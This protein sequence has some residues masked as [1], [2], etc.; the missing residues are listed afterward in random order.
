MILE[1]MSRL[2]TCLCKTLEDEGRPTNFCGVIPGDSPVAS[3]GG[4]RDGDCGMA[5][6]R[7]MTANMASGIG[8]PNENP[9]NCG[10]ELG[11]EVEVGTLRCIDVDVDYPS[12]AELL[13]QTEQQTKDAEAIIRAIACCSSFNR[14]DFILGGY[15]PMGPMGGYLGGS[16]S[17]RLVARP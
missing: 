11:I 10:A 3:Y 17:V 13:A 4:E 7:L 15:T 16:W 2:A 14:S 5:W 12:D 6:V 8:V 1:T 9:G